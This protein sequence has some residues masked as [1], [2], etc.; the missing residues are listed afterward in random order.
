MYQY[1][2][3]IFFQFIIVISFLMG[4]YLRERVKNRDVLTRFLIK[5]NLFVLEP[6]LAFWTGWNIRFSS[7]LL[8]LP[9]AG[10][11]VAVMTFAAGMFLSRYTGQ[12]SIRRET[13]TISSSLS[14]Q[15]YT[16]GAFICYI[17]L[18]EQGL[19]LALL[20]IIY[21]FFF[22]YGFIFTYASFKG[23]GKV[24]KVTLAVLFKKFFTLNNMPMYALIA[25]LLLN[26]LGINRPEIEINPDIFIFPVVI[27][28]FI[29]LGLSYNLKSLSFFSRSS[30][31]MFLLKFIAAPFLGIV[32]TILFNVDPLYTKI[33]IAE[34]MMP[35]AVYSV[36]TANLFK[37]DSE[38]A[39]SLFVINTVHFLIIS[40]PLFY[41]L[42]RFSFI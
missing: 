33:I 17:L 42:S 18:G 36:V 20:L 1:Y 31:F 27:F 39:A 32:F 35:V 37:L 29:M 14:N 34:S 2:R 4:N 12:S 38:Y 22:T 8:F 41:F 10:L 30:M 28:S 23:S 21:F 11:F 5:S 40:F 9:T 6:F 16:M 3:F 13:F 7:D 15:G 25:A 26:R 24:E 19:A